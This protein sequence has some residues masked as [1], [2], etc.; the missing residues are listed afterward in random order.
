MS[1]LGRW[2]ETF[3]E[4]VPLVGYSQGGRIALLVAL[5]YPDLVDR[6]VLISA[7]LGVRYETD[8]EARRMRDGALADRIQAIGLDGFLDEWLEGSVVGTSHLSDQVRRADRIVR[9][10]NT[11]GG[12]ASALRGLG[13]G[14]QPFVGDR[15]SELKMPVLTVSG[16]RD[17]KYTRLAAEI[18]DAVPDGRHVSIPDVGHNVVLETPDE[19]AAVLGEFVVSSQ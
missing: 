15:L 10:E 14:S 13:Q 4:P 16:A 8:R 5:E 6:L 3:D 17:E 12:L 18:A 19:L 2:L 1:A 11:A 9:N 7:S